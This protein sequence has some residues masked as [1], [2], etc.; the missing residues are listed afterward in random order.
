MISKEFKIGNYI[1]INI[2]G[3]GNPSGN[4][5]DWTEITA[6]QDG[7][8]QAVCPFFAFTIKP[9]APPDTIEK[10]TAHFYTDDTSNT[11]VLRNVANCVYLEVHGRNEVEN[12]QDVPV[13]DKLRNKA[14]ALGGIIGLGKLNWDAFTKGLLKPSEA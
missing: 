12:T 3:P 2:P 7:M 14:I 8:D 9:C 4:G 10:A 11:F 13:L 5:F 1:K 6:I